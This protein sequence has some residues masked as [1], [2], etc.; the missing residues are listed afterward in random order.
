MKTK[1]LGALLENEV[2]KPRQRQN[3]CELT[4]E[5]ENKKGAEE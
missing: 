4:D 2:K 5:M 3:C 1:K